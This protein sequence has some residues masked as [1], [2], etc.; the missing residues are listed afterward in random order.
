M[1]AARQRRRVR[2]EECD[3]SGVVF[4][5]HLY[6]Y[7]DGALRDLARERP[8]IAPLIPGA[9]AGEDGEGAARETTLRFLRPMRFGDDLDIEV[10]VADLGPSTVAWELAVLRDGEPVAG[11]SIVHAFVGSDGAERELPGPLREALESL[12]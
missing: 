10:R 1:P 9:C 8:A 11:G 12:G 4:N 6:S 5:A 2:Y 3:P 7:L